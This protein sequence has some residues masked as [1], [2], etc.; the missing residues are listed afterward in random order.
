MVAKAHAAA[1]HSVQL[2]TTHTLQ[3]FI[4]TDADRRKELAK[5]KHLFLEGFEKDF[6]QGGE[7]PY[8]YYQQIEIEEFLQS[9]RDAGL[10]NNYSVVNQWSSVK[11]WTREFIAAQGV[12]VQEIKL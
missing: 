8:T 6:A 9:R 11:W 3:H 1:G 7:C 5:I 12:A 10:I 2:L 4:S